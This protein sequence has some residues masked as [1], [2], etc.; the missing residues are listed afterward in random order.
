MLHT[1][2]RLRSMKIRSLLLC[3]ALLFCAP[4]TFAAAAFS[5]DGPWVARAY[6]TQPGQLNVIAARTAPWEVNR[7][8]S[9]AII[10]IANRFEL[11]Q[12]RAF[13]LRLVPDADRTAL[14]RKPVQPLAKG[15]KSIPGFACYRTVEET[16]AT[17]NQLLSSFPT[18]ASVIDIGDSWEKVRNPA[19]GYDLRVLKLTNQAIPGPK[20]VFF[21]MSSV[22]AREYTPAEL[23][24]RLAEQLLNGY[25]VDPDLTA[26]LDHQEVHLLLQ[27][28]P[29]GRKR[30]EGALSWR[31][32]TNEAFC[33]PTSNSRGADLNRN[34]PFGWGAYNGSSTVQCDTTYR[35]PAAASEPETQAIIQY[36]RSIFADNRGPNLLDPAPLTTPGLFFDIHSYSQLV[37]WPYGFDSDPVAPGNQGSA[38]DAPLRTLGRRFAWFNNYMPQQAIELYVTD[39][40]TLDF[41]YG[42]LGV[43]AYTFELGN[44]FFEPCAAFESTVLPDN[45]RALRYALKVTRAPYLLPAGPDAL[46]MIG[47]LIAPGEPVFVAATLDDTPFSLRNGTDAVHSIA[48][49]QVFL[50]AQLPWLPSAAP[51]AAMNAIDGS[52]NQPRERA[53][54]Q[55]SA[56]LSAGRHQLFVQATDSSGAKGP[57][58]S[59]FVDV[60]DAK[61]TARI[62]GVV[63]DA[64]NNAP[65]RQAVL[66]RSERLGTASNASDGSYALRLMPGSRTLSA[67]TAGYLDASLAP[68]NLVAGSNT[69]QGFSLTPICPALQDLFDGD[70]SAWT[71]QAPWATT[72]TRSVSAPRSFTDSPAGNYA[73]NANTAL[74]SPLINT[75]G[76]SKL[77]LNFASFCATQATGDFGRVDLSTDG[78]SSFSEI[79]RC[80]GRPLWEDVRLTLPTATN[81]AAVRVRFRLT[82][83][84]S[85]TNEGWYIDNVRLLGGSLS[86]P[87]TDDLIFGDGFGG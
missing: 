57:V 9:Y 50:D 54:A 84:A 77:E 3:V 32:N 20:P 5:D 60:A 76:F 23:M 71:A 73:N 86:C 64:R 6:F 79:W 36:V 82:S 41:A 52:F 28:N 38:N 22:H 16:N 31:K 19:N 27:A 58:G 61:S 47:S 62:S 72:T 87:F 53:S 45:L 46:D 26:I 12:W 37:L 33:S 67:S 43:A 68:L 66:I 11:K 8:E 59:A 40:T 65:L 15:A 39:G 21:A 24:T 81:Q 48:Q 7:E 30:A 78:G 70:V 44:A 56:A 1:S 55:F 10:E 4:G 69:T 51:S 13:G 2:I 63:R 49:S 83:D 80:S 25:G 18:L 29:D 75:Q 34:F 74:I 35:G 17:I 14:I 42:E 85:T